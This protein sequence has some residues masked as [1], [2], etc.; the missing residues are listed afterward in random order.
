MDA[1]GIGWRTVKPRPRRCGWLSRWGSDASRS[2][3]QA[4]PEQRL[5]DLAIGLAHWIGLQLGWARPAPRVGAALE[6]AGAPVA[7]VDVQGQLEMRETVM[8][9]LGRAPTLTLRA[10]SPANRR[11]GPLSNGSPGRHPTAGKV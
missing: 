7:L 1:S 9:M 10:P 4:R 2:D 3:G 8:R 5:G 11:A 6:A